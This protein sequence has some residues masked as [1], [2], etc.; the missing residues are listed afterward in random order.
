MSAERAPLA[1]L[2][3]RETGIKSKLSAFGVI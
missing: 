1:K 3:T 2:D